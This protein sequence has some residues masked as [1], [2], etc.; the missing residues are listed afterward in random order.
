MK[1]LFQK[2][3]LRA[4]L[5]AS[6]L[7][8]CAVWAGV[9]DHYWQDVA[10]RSLPADAPQPAQFRALA[11]DNQKMTDYLRQ[12]HSNGAAVEVSLPLPE[13]DFSDF[14]VVDSG[15][16]PTQLQQK[17]PDILSFQGR[18]AEGRR[19]RLDVSP[20]GFQAMVFDPEGIW[21]VRPQ[22]VA[23]GTDQYLSYRRAELDVPGMQWQCETHGDVP[24]LDKALRG[25]AQPKTVT[26]TNQRVY[27]AAI[28]ANN[29][30]IAAVGGGTVAGG[31]AATTVAVNRVNELYEHEMS[32]RFQLV[33]NND[34]IMYANAGSDPFNNQDDIWVIN[35][36]TSI[37]NGVIGSSNYDVGHVFSTSGG[38]VAGLRVVCGSSK[39]RGTTGLPNPVGD[40]FYIDYVA[41]EMGHQFGGNHPFNG[42]LGNCTGGNRNGST[43]YEPGSGS[44]IM[45]YAGIC[46]GDNLQ[47]HSD[48]YFHAI[49]LQEITNF[50]NAGGNCSMNTPNPNQPP[51]IDTLSLPTGMTIP[52]Q[53]PF[54]LTAAAD[55]PNPGDTLGYSWEQW[56]LGPQ[57]PLSAGDNGSSPLFRTWRPKPTGERVFP[58]MSTVLGGPALKGE[59]LPTK[60]RSSMKFRL[61]VRDR[62]DDLLGSGTSQ[63]ADI[64]LAVTSTAGPFKVNSPS[65]GVILSSGA[66]AS[67][68]W[69][70]A[71]TTATPVSCHSVDIDLS[72]D[73]GTSF[74]YALATG[75]PNSG[76]ASF[77]VP[78]VSTTQARIRVRCSNNVFFNVSPGNFTIAPGGSV[79]SVGGEVNG[80]A[81]SGLKLRINGGNDL[82]VTA[83]GS[84][85]FTGGLLDG[86]TYAV[87]VASQPINPFQECSVTNGSG[88]INGADV[89]DVQVTCVN[90]PTYS[91]GGTIL[92]LTTP[93]LK[94]KLNAGANLDVA[95]NA[96]SFTFPDE[97]L[98]HANYN[99][100]ISAQP[101]GQTCTI[102]NN[103]GVV[104][105]ADV[106]DVHVEC[107]DLPPES[108]KVGGTV[109]NYNQ[110]TSTRMVLQLNGAE[111]LTIKWSGNFS[112][113]TD[114]VT[115]DSYVVTI[116]TQPDG[117][118]CR[119]SNATGTMGYADVTD[120]HIDCAELPDEIFADGFEGDG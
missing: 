77:P 15:T 34:L 2:P 40:D 83:N 86:Q 44:T 52:V 74:T 70:V 58:S 120:V 26:G 73:G 49:S 1:T 37:I 117:Q 110:N 36:A 4:L 61:T 50:T 45:S 62:S 29:K 17:Y 6:L 92:G 97:L 116:L 81:G 63:S 54:V 51:V 16:L 113:K 79:Y 3:F 106:T 72:T 10:Q 9:T 66:T 91:V 114:V 55:D 7:G 88:T 18:D 8:P 42:Q 46:S 102:A 22:S 59:T 11:L 107:E 75:V 28:A 20:L 105:G 78:V 65:A 90:L 64:A 85:Q 89:T 101:L 68:S 41:H 48:P 76:N 82:T 118:S 95:A 27:R 93:G 94:L 5:L 31:L 108:H 38:G 104:S 115:G 32:I 67:T 57:A 13:G 87:T 96:S 33:P 35:N 39:A 100:T 60:T 69:D 12:A 14:T 112:F 21:V 80:L 109:V 111:N 119:I 71:N 53:T 99:V 56:D 84:F 103:S 47:D 98:N 24:D 25:P 30:Y 23:T 19:V 43:A